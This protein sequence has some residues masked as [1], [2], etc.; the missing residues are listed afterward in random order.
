MIF[1]LGGSNRKIASTRSKRRERR[2]EIKKSHISKCLFGLWSIGKWIFFRNRWFIFSQLKPKE[3]ENNETIDGSHSVFFK[4]KKKN[5][6][7]Y[8]LADRKTFQTKTVLN[9]CVC[10][11]IFWTQV[12]NATLVPKIMNLPHGS[13]DIYLIAQII[14]CSQLPNGKQMI[15]RQG[16]RERD[17]KER[18]KESQ[19]FA[20]CTRLTL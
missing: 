4:K 2:D 16:E 15:D 14:K 3:T 5:S 6:T 13:N 11:C 1:H 20:V 17:T 12:M 8:W 18:T 10:V 19:R 9:V 7:I